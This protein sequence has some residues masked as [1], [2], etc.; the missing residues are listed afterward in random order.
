MEKAR[1]VQKNILFCF[2]DYAI[3]FDCMDNNKLWK[4]L[5][6]MAVSNYFICL[7][8]KL[9]SGHEQQLEIDI[10]QLTDYKLQKKYA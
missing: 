8:R 4:I 10:D 2:I 9:H 6:V 1:G 5:K 7:L 3:P